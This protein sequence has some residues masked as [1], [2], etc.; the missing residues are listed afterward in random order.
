ML[1]SWKVM[2]DSLPVGPPHYGVLS[3]DVGV[4]GRIILLAELVFGRKADTCESGPPRDNFR[5]GA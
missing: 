4:K 5:F 1:I 3:T 2:T